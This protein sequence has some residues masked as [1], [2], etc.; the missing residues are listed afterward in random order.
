MKLILVASMA[1]AAQPAAAVDGNSSMLG[2]TAQ[3]R[4]DINAEA[5][6]LSDH[7]VIHLGTRDQV[8]GSLAF[9]YALTF[10]STFPSAFL[11]AFFFPPL[12]PFLD[13]F[14][15]HVMHLV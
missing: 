12:G 11:S 15:Q 9:R 7:L 13:A 3:L 8:T 6:D 10:L 14:G 2:L 4:N 5:S 1:L